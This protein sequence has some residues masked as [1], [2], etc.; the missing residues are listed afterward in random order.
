MFGNLGRLYF[1]SRVT[2]DSPNEKCINKFKFYV[3]FFKKGKTK[4]NNAD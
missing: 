4:G 3:E 2:K 1:I